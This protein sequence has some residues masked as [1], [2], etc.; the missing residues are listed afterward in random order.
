MKD[1]RRAN[2]PCHDLDYNNPMSSERTRAVKIIFATMACI[3]AASDGFCGG[4]QHESR[5]V[6]E[7]IVSGREYSINA[8]ALRPYWQYHLD[9]SANRIDE[10]VLPIEPGDKTITV[11]GVGTGR[12]MHLPILAEKADLLHLVDIDAVG[13][14]E[15]LESVP[16]PLQSK[17]RTHIVDITGGQ[18]ETILERAAQ[19]IA[20]AAPDSHGQAAALDAIIALYDGPAFPLPRD[21]L[22]AFRASRVVSSCVSSQILAKPAGFIE[23]AFLEKFRD[24]A[25]KPVHLEDVEDYLYARDVGQQ[26]VYRQHA[27]SLA[28][29]AKDNGRVY[30]SDTVG[31]TP[32]LNRFEPVGMVLL[33]AQLLKEI[34]SWDWANLF[35]NAGKMALAK[36]LASSGV[37]QYSLE[38]IE[39]FLR[40]FTDG[41]LSTH[42]MTFILAAMNMAIAQGCL[43]NHCDAP[44]IPIEETIKLSETINRIANGIS[45]YVSA[46]MIPGG[47][48][49]HFQDLLTKAGDTAEWNWLAHPA[50][51][52]AGMG[53]FYHIQAHA[54]RKIGQ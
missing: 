42:D 40:A 24:P 43:P 19:A 20:Q 22:D 15:A 31:E 35:S 14:T 34:R 23:R 16:G 51:V 41:Q 1:A 44:F 48:E 7:A 6:Q 28:Y 13:L 21:T 47:M 9:R 50:D 33:S 12:E 38:Q 11:I 17:V 8:S 3:Y 29:L 37:K 53:G 18:M 10:V 39:T 26:R 5:L 54:L 4:G 52:M 32:M 49:R 27:E 2:V 45:P 46:D 25:G 30:W 36:V